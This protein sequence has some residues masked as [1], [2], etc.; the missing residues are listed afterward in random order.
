MS[1]DLPKLTGCGL[2]FRLMTQLAILQRPTAF[3]EA[4]PDIKKLVAAQYAGKVSDHFLLNLLWMCRQLLRTRT[5]CS[6]HA[7]PSL[8]IPLQ[9]GNQSNMVVSLIGGYAEEA[10]RKLRQE[11][12]MSVE[13][14]S[15][16]DLVATCK[17]FQDNSAVLRSILD[18]VVL[19][20]RSSPRIFFVGLAK[21][22]SDSRSSK[23]LVEEV[24]YAWCWCFLCVLCACFRFLS[25][26]L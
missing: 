12:I 17:Y 19:M 9:Q 4:A 3:V 24:D 18:A 10:S 14:C 23:G 25:R 21:L 6:L 5:R 22:L 20:K 8:L 15:S 1:Y 26:E 13:T 7:I 16:R 11:E 2:G